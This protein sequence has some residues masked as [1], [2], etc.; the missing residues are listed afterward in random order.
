MK[1][2]LLCEPCDICPMRK[3]EFCTFDYGELPRGKQLRDDYWDRIETIKIVKIVAMSNDAADN[4]Y[5]PMHMVADSTDSGYAT[6]VK[7]FNEFASK[8]KYPQ[9]DDLTKEQMLGK[10]DTHDLK[11]ML[12]E[13]CS[14]ILDY[15]KDIAGVEHIACGTQNNISRGQ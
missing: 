4:R 9:L 2:L 3:A 13:F 1:Y 7:R 11:H 5:E 14:F 12:S 15:K 6:A 10:T 8:N